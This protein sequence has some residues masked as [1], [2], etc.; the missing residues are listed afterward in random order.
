M[1]SKGPGFYTD[2]YG[3]HGGGGGGGMGGEIPP[4]SVSAS[5]ASP[6]ALGH[7]DPIQVQPSE[8]HHGKIILLKLYY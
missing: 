3:A 8:Y 5:H 4:A 7:M 2:Q 1:S 6:S